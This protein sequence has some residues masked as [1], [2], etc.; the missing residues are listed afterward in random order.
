MYSVSRCRLKKLLINF[1]L[2]K[3]ALKHPKIGIR[4]YLAAH[5]KAL[6]YKDVEFCKNNSLPITDIIQS[7]T[8][9]TDF[10][11]NEHE[12][13][14]VDL[15]VHLLKF[16]KLI[17][18]IQ[19]PSKEK[20][21]DINYA[22]DFTTGLFLYSLIRVTKPEIV[23]ETGT[24]YGFSSSFILQALENN[25]TGELFSIDY[26]FNPW[27]T[28]YMIGKAIPK[29]LRKRWTLIF[30]PSV[31]KL[32]DLLSSQKPDI[33]IHD[34]EHTYKNMLFEFETV[35]PHLNENGFILSD[36]I[37][38]NNAFHEFYK[39]HNLI[40]YFLEQKG[41]K[42]HN[43]DLTKLFGILEKHRNSI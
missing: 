35:F 30:G 11:I 8:S 25:E 4:N 26:V 41:R 39:K 17:E 22:I 6:P 16:T 20:P 36:D 19:W 3:F 24:A 40:P 1:E 27:Q 34:S 15:K 37:L 9:V 12:K 31:D 43:S 13:E 32:S 23:I 5:E 29:N 14:L 7:I 2:I 42:H 21:Y 18:K 38:D 33:F 28:K 10:K